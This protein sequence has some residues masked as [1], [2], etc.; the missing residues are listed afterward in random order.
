[1]ILIVHLEEKSR[2]D[3]IIGNEEQWIGAQQREVG[4]ALT[5]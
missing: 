1:V 5:S 4:G 3:K 2:E